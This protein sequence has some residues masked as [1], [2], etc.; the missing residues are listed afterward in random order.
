MS[1]T[2]QTGDQLKYRMRKGELDAFD[3]LYRL[4]EEH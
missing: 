4:T 2:P 1:D 3:A